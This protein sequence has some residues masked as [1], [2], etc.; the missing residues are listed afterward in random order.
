MARISASL[1][2]INSLVAANNPA[3]FRDRDL[4]AAK[5]SALT[6]FNNNRGR[7]GEFET[8]RSS[9]S[10]NPFSSIILARSTVYRKL[11]DQSNF[12]RLVHNTRFRRGLNSIVWRG[13]LV[14]PGKLCRPSL[15]LYRFS[16]RERKRRLIIQNRWK[17]KW[18]IFLEFFCR[19]RRDG[20]NVLLRLSCIGSREGDK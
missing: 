12:D 16:L 13:Y 2:L 9:S 3:S 17:G 7:K 20:R 18:G 11:E 10:T 5:S 6:N 15:L 1:D 14:S 8:R 19:I 4:D